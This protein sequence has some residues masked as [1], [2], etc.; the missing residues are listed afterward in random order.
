MEKENS[1]SRLMRIAK[2]VAAKFAP[3]TLTDSMG[4]IK[5]AKNPRTPEWKLRE[6]AEDDNE[7]VRIAVAENPSTPPD[8]LMALSDDESID[9]RN[10]VSQNPSAM[11]FA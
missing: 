3:Y 7:Y 9:V 10:A 11:S 8:V 4:K 6:L 5:A 1:E 2:A